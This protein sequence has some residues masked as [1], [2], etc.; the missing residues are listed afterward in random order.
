MKKFLCFKWKEPYEKVID[1]IV[2]AREEKTVIE[3]TDRYLN[4]VLN[5]EQS[6]KFA[7]WI[8]SNREWLNPKM[9]TETELDRLQR[10]MPLGCTLELRGGI[11]IK[12]YFIFDF[13]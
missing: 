7:E 11:P 1:S 9:S 4:A 10:K 5:A 2:K 3:F 6:R 12:T 13:S 8:K